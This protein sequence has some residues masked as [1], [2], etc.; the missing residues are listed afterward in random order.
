MVKLTDSKPMDI[1]LTDREMREFI[2][3][4]KDKNTANKDEMKK[5]RSE[6][7][8]FRKIRKERHGEYGER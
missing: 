4:S 2:R 7:S 8:A 1:K 6:I 5:L 3:W